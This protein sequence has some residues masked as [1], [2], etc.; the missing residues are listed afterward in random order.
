MIQ[1]AFFSFSADS[2][3]SMAGEEEEVF[4]IRRG[5]KACVIEQ[6]AA[7]RKA[8]VGMVQR[9]L[10]YRGRRNPAVLTLHAMDNPRTAGSLILNLMRRP[11]AN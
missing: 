8:G 9:T 7:N 1:S 6:G 5:T 3:D 10:I 4:V 11:R 2:F